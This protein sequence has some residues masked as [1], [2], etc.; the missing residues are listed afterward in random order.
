MVECNYK[1]FKKNLDK[2]NLVNILSLAKQYSVQTFLFNCNDVSKTILFIKDIHHFWDWLWG[3]YP[4]LGVEGY[5]ND[6]LNIIKNDKFI[7]G[8][9]NILK[10]NPDVIGFCCSSSPMHIKILKNQII[11]EY[12]NAFENKT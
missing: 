5:S 11:K 10:F 9:E 6:Y 2:T 1:R 4:N 12:E 8:K 3:L 7:L